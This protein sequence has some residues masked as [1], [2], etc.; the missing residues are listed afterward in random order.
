MSTVRKGTRVRVAFDDEE[1]PI[2]GELL[3]DHATSLNR[4]RS[5][6]TI[7]LDDGRTVTTDSCMWLP[8]NRV[9]PL[10]LTPL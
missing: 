7:L 1:T 10:P 6:T 3:D 8:C 2:L 9:T 5:S 4:V